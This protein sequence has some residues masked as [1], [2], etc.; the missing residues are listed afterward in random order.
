VVDDG[1]YGVFALGR[2]LA[3]FDFSPN[4]PVIKRTSEDLSVLMLLAPQAGQH[5]RLQP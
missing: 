3:P 2:L 4:N 1:V 5:T